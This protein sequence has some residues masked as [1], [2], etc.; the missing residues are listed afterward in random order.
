[1]PAMQMMLYRQRLAANNTL[2]ALRVLQLITLTSM[3]ENH[4]SSEVRYNTAVTCNDFQAVGQLLCE[5]LYR[6][7]ILVSHAH[8][9]GKLPAKDAIAAI[10]A[11]E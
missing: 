3:S 2:A 6:H 4:K 11:Q 7:T 1:M 8:T 5:T 9:L 10:K